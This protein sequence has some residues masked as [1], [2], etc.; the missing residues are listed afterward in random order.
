MK[1]LKKLWVVLE[2]KKKRPLGNYYTYTKLNPYNPLTY[3]YLIIAIP[4][5]I[6]QS[7]YNDMRESLKDTFKW[8]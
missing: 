8:T 1:I 3:I 4:I 5:A 6:W 7:G 2:R